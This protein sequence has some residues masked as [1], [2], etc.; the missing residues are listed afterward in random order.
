MVEEVRA[1]SLVNVYVI[2]EVVA[3][4][5]ILELGPTVLTDGQTS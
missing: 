1:D 3:F 5:E 4:L 2:L